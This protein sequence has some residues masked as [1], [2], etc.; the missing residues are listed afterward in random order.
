MRKP[1]FA[2]CEQQR[3]RSAC[4]SAQSNQRL[5]IRYLD[6][7]ISVLSICKISIFLTYHFKYDMILKHMSTYKL[8][9][10]TGIKKTDM[11]YFSINK[12]TFKSFTDKYSISSAC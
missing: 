11:T 2:I 3:S 12:L 6:S 4:A 7:I 8:I 10:I 9:H 1:V 5:V